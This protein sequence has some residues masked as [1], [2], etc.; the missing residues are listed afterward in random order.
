MYT[1][2]PDAVASRVNLTSPV[3][4]AVHSQDSLAAYGAAVLETHSPSITHSLVLN[5]GFSAH[6]A[7]AVG[8]A[9]G[10]EVGVGLGA[11]LILG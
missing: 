9:V 10:R 7:G 2:S 4:K 1:L 8:L 3:S 6:P 11:G 5:P